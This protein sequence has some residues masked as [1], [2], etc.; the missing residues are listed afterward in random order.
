MKK[1]IVVLPTLPNYRKDFFNTLS[2]QLANNDIELEVFH[3]LTKKRDIQGIDQKNF[4]TI[5]F[6]TTEYSLKGFT[7]AILKGLKQRI[8][9]SSP[10]GV[11]VLFNP[12]NVSLV[13]ILLYSLKKK[14]PY[15]LWSCGWIRPNINGLLSKVRE[16]F[17]EYFEQRAC[18]HIAYHSMRKSVLVKKGIPFNSVFV[19][20]NTIDTEAI[21]N[22]YNLKEVNK[23][24]FNGK[25]KVLFVGGL[26]K[27]KYLEEAMSVVDNLISDNYQI[28][29]TIIGGGSTIENLKSYRESLKNKNEIHIMGPKYG[30]ELQPYFLESDV[31]L[32][33]GSGGLAINEA[34]AYGLPIISTDGDGSGFDLIEGNGYLLHEVGNKTEIRTALS[35]FARLPRE[36]KLEMSENSLSIIKT[37]ATNSLMVKHFMEAILFMLNKQK[38]NI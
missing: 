19:A 13:N 32:L 21:I 18:V 22:S 28:S 15:A 34:M 27:G 3:G 26:I 5:S 16:R 20:Q 29:F 17:L 4:K 35:T 33:P 9:K 23:K 11:V 30:G 31:F 10:D 1:I 8:V 36:Q 25:L 38:N 14:I 24:R 2:A 6:D 37:K 12:A 7:L